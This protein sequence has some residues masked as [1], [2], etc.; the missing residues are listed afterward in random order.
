MNELEIFHPQVRKGPYYIAK[1]VI[2]AFMNI[3]PE[4]SQ[5]K[6]IISLISRLH[7]PVT[8]FNRKIHVCETV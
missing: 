5:V 1:Y 6:T 7:N 3:V 8:S 4:F 2:T